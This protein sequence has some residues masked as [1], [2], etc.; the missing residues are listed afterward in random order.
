[1]M[2][3]LMTQREPTAAEALFGHLPKAESAERPQRRAAQ[4]IA[5]AM[6]PA[7]ASQPKPKP[8]PHPLLPRLKRAGE[9]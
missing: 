9:L 2:G 1:M 6:F 3:A 4:S 5:D 7:L 8:P